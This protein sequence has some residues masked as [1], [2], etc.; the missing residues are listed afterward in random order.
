MTS[1]PFK[2]WKRSACLERQREILADKSALQVEVD[3]LERQEEA[4]GDSGTI[5]VL[6]ESIKLLNMV[7][8]LTQQQTALMQEYQ[9]INVELHIRSD[10]NLV[11]QLGPGAD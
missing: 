9:E 4:L 2:S 11:A 7:R 8:E 5:Q 3:R 6:S 10:P 1:R